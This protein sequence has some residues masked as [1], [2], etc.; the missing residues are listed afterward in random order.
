MRC[1]IQIDAA[2]L[3]HNYQ[4]FQKIAPQATLVP[5]VKSNAYGHGLRE[6]YSALSELNPAWLA[7]NYLAEASV[8]RS[9]GFA[10][11]ILV[12]GPIRAS[13]LSLALQ[14][15]CD[16]FLAERHLLEA[17]QQLPAAQ[18]PRAHVKFDTGMSRQG[19]M[20][21]EAADLIIALRQ[22]RSQSRSRLVGICSH[23][24]N[25]ED[26]LE[27]SYA[28]GQLDS[29]MAIAAAFKAD[30]Y[31][32]MPHIA[33]SSSALI[34]QDSRLAMIRVGISIYGL[35]PSRA[36]QL[37]YLQSFG[38]MLELK[39]LLSWTTEVA[40]VKS[41][42]SGQFIGYG[43]TFKALRDMR[44]ALL[45]VGYYEGYPRLASNRGHVLIEGQRCPIVGR[46]CMNMMMVDV[47]HLNAIEVGA[48]VTLIGH[49]GDEHIDASQI[50]EWAETIHYE[51]LTQLNPAIPRL[52]R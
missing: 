11:R 30:G 1:Q 41:I 51:I 49:S 39:P 19:F 15:D 37:S 20:P 46:I 38:H 4:I 22:Q 52:L 45:P 28:L 33:A 23:F 40:L 10:A 24:S 8:L 17:W 3:R 5:V 47:S 42:K 9:L 35:W 34:M 31:Q 12:V 2:A 44:I 48:V 21:D 50:G 25:V 16:I 36:T 13:D 6:V 43:C 14:L 32:L 18:Q 7:V 27:Q 29:F 26:V